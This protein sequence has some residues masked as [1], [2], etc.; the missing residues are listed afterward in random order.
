MK[1]TK[2]YSTKFSL[3]PPRSMHQRRLLNS[4]TQQ[5]CEKPQCK[6]HFKKERKSLDMQLNS[7]ALAQHASPALKEKNRKHTELQ[8]RTISSLLSGIK[9]NS[10]DL[11]KLAENHGYSLELPQNISRISISTYFKMCAQ[12]P[13]LSTKIKCK[14]CVQTK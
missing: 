8:L 11:S 7:K 12:P 5:N 13:G 3:Y 2:D 1:A 4:Q 14:M 9:V 6:L 10:P